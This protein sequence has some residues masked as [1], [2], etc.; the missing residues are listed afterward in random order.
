MA[1]IGDRRGVTVID[2]LVLDDGTIGMLRVGQSSGY[3]DIDR[4]VE[5]IIASIGH[6]PPLPQWIQGPSMQLEFRLRFPEALRE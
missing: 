2:L 4:R 5:Q 3:P 1:V 6:F